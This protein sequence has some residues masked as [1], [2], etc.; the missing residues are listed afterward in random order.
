MRTQIT[1]F[2]NQ[3]LDKTATFDSGCFI[4]MKEVF[5]DI[6][7]YEGYYQVS[8]LG[9][10]KRKTGKILKPF[11]NTN[12]YLCVKFCI[13]GIKKHFKV[14]QLVAMAFLNHVPN[15]HKIV[16]DHINNIKTDNSVDNLQLITARENTSKDKKNGT[17]KYIGVGWDKTAKKWKC[18]IY[19]NGIS[20]H[21]GYFINDYDAHL[22]YQKE[23]SCI[24][25]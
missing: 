13:N 6:K 20:K 23:L 25:N 9:T 16:V 1:T 11:K 17:S 22:V 19:K 14:H 12:G 7:G 10:V 18:Q 8:N 21:L 5:K 4:F 2:K 3:P 24:E 15:G